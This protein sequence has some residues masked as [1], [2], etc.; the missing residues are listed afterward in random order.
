VKLVEEVRISKTMW[1]EILTE[2]LGM[3]GVAAKFVLCLMSEDQQQS[4]VDVSKEL[5]DCVNADVPLFEE[6][7]HSR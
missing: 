4:H 3:H 1:R 7:H 2:N 6:H 5:V